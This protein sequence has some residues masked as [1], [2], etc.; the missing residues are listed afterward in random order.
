[1]SEGEKKESSRRNNKMSRFIKE[2]KLTD[3]YVC[4]IIFLTITFTLISS[5]ESRI[6]YD[7]INYLIIILACVFLALHLILFVATLVKLVKILRHN[8]KTPI[9]GYLFTQLLSLSSLSCGILFI[10]VQF[11]LYSIA[12]FIPFL[13]ISI[14]ILFLIGLVLQKVSYHFFDISAFKLKQTEKEIIMLI[15]SIILGIMFLIALNYYSR[16]ELLSMVNYQI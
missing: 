10:A 5:F 1:M 15:M 16:T 11:T 3:I 13:V 4:F 12:E 6:N 8:K 14:L 9:F 2:I 7:P